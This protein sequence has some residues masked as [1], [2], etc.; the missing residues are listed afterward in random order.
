V[1]QLPLGVNADDRLASG[2]EQRALLGDVGELGGAIG[3]VRARLE[4]LAVDV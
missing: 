2:G 4:L 3:V 1:S